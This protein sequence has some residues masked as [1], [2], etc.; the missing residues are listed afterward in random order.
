MPAGRKS[1]SDLSNVRDT[2]ES[3]WVAI[4][5]AFVLRAFMVEAFV[6]PTG[7]MAPRLMGRHWDLRCPACGYTYAFGYSTSESRRSR[8]GRHTPERALCPN[9]GCPYGESMGQ[10]LD[11]G[12][13]VLV[14][15][16]LYHFGELRAPRPWDVAVFKNPQDNR[17]N[18]IKRLIGTPGEMVQ[19][20]HGDIFYRTGEDVNGDGVINRADF[21]VN[22]DGQLTREDWDDPGALEENP[23]RVRTKSREAQE[24][25]WQVVFDNDY[26]PHL[27]TLRRYAEQENVEVPER[28]WKAPPEWDLSGDGGRV[29]RFSGPRETPVLFDAQREVFLPTYG[30]N[31]RDRELIPERTDSPINP[32]KDVCTDLKLGF[33]LV[34]LG[35]REGGV[36]LEI[37]ALGHRYRGV[38]RYDGTAELWHRPEESDW[39]GE[40]VAT[41]RTPALRPNVGHRV[42]LTHA[43]LTVTLWV[44]GRPIAKMSPEQYPLDYRALSDLYA[45]DAPISPPEVQLAA[46]G[47]DVELRHVRLVRDVYYTSQEISGRIPSEPQYRYVAMLER[48]GLLGE[49]RLRGWGCFGRPIVLRKFNDEPELDEFYVLG[50]NSPQSLDS[51]LWISAAP[52]LKLWRKDGRFLHSYARGAE[53][54]YKLGTVPRYS[55]IGKALFVYWPAG[56]RVPGLP[57]LP[58]I[59]NVGE[60]RVIR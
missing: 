25:M 2:V 39:P 34:P 31:L 45:S 54:V 5:L 33:V 1:K 21:D 19:I 30:Y 50:D 6:I 15:K 12:D 41:G 53:P 58:I 23:W 14:L 3:V 8:G 46:F 36:S 18:Y 44:D 47:A 60:V 28:Q 55:M 57:Q 56:F 51:R 16:Y 40:P 7:S 37:A 20:V 22:G 32:Q 29:W 24:A 26:Q 27:P 49:D 48:L 13:R 17:Q 11:S 35:G 9:C 10:Y 52:S 42:A 43:D 59:P 4:V 38:L